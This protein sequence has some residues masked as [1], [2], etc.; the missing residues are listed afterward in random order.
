MFNLLSNFAIDL[1]LPV[2]KWLTIGVVALAII[3]L[4]VIYFAKK[5]NFSKWVKNIIGALFVFLLALGLAC[6]IMEISKKYSESYAEENWLDRLALI[7]LVLVPISALIFTL[8]GSLVAI[9]IVSKKTSVSENKKPLSLT[10]KICGAI[11]LAVLILCGVLMA[12]YYNAKFANDGY[13]NS[14]TASVN[15]AVL[16][17][18][19]VLL[20]VALASL[21]FIL[22]ANGGETNTKSI[23]LAG[24]CIAMSFGLSYVKIFEMPQGGAITLFSLLPI[25]IY[26]FIYGTKKGVLICLIYGV[27]QAVQDP[28]IIHPA[29]FALD[30]PI[31]FAGIGLSGM[32]ASVKGLK[33]K[34]QVAFLIGGIIASLFRFISHVL[35]GV[36]AFSA[37]AEG[38]NPWVYSLGYNS[39][40]FIDIAITLVAGVILFSSKAFVRELTKSTASR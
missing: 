35:S 8:L 15:Q 9:F 2:A 13:Y 5:E 19:A 21:A 40:V 4:F 17:I 1:F 3:L 16:Y 22:D 32:L 31:A 28:F 12:V 11:S 18:S 34:P 20:V 14:Q 6:L 24:V 38:A 26:S 36:F 27:L 30:Y 10:V 33:N 39:F 25:M 29:Q 37:Y 7:K 23:A